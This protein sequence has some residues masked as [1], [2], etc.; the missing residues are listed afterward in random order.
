MSA[1]SAHH[2]FITI[3][4]QNRLCSASDSTYSYTFSAMWSV[5]LFVVSLVWPSVIFVSSR[6]NRAAD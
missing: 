6:L 5:C 4:K 3:I 1:S 2:Q